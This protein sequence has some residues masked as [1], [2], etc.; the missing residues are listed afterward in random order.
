MIAVAII[1]G[2]VLVY[3]LGVSDGKD[4]LKNEINDI[5]SRKGRK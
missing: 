1:I 4:K 2:F 3:A 5:F